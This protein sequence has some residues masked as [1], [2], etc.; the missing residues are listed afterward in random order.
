MVLLPWCC[1]DEEKLESWIRLEKWLMKGSR[2]MSV[3][4]CGRG[5]PLYRARLASHYK[6]QERKSFKTP[7]YLAYRVVRKVG[8]YKDKNAMRENENLALYLGRLK[9]PLITTQADLESIEGRVLLA[10]SFITQAVP[11]IER[12]LQKN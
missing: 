11:D 4:P 7:H 8:N 1:N 12:I 10:Q 9:K 6:R 5:N 2:W 3:W